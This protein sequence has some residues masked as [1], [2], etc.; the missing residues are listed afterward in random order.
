MTIE[1]IDMD[2][3][4]SMMAALNPPSDA[5]NHGEED[6]GVIAQQEPCDENGTGFGTIVEMHQMH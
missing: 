2:V 5:S 6:L 1:D 3:A 4:A